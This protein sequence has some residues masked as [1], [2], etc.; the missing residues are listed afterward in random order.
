MGWPASH[1]RLKVIL[2][3]YE[4]D[5]HKGLRWLLIAFSFETPAGLFPVGASIFGV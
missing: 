1:R 5:H 4:Q 2:I 3:F